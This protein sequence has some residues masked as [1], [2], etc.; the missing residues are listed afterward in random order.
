[1]LTDRENRKDKSVSSFS[2][3][4]LFWVLLLMDPCETCPPRVFLFKLMKIRRKEIKRPIVNI[5][6][7]TLKNDMNNG[8]FLIIS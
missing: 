5:P 8:P 3:S 1:M 7:R 6:S 2:S 4:S